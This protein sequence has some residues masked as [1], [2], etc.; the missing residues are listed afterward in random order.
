M[1]KI[2][3]VL[4]I[5]AAVIACINPDKKTEK[6]ETAVTV[7]TIDSFLVTDS[8][9][10]AIKASAGFDNLKEIFGK[11]NIKNERICGAECIDSV[12]VTILFGGTKNESII[13]WKDS[14][15]LREISFIE[16]Y[17][18]SAS[19]HTS[20]GISMGSGL[21]ELL[22]LN[23]K[24]IGFY[25]FGWDYGGTIISYNGG[26]LDGSNIRFG[27]DITGYSGN[28]L[29]GDNELDTE[30]PSVKAALDKIRVRSI[31]LSFNK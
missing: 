31:A 24:K 16:S 12:D 1:K 2:I 13:Y 25:G 3:P 9:W 28:E 23:E 11:A 29:Y 5:L 20:A 4:F 7:S 10:G 26:K 22:K 6:T 8:S 19:W 14:A 17:N 27:L 15:Y 21:Q 30:M 18:D